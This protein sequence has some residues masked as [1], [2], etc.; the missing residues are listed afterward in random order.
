[1]Q[2]LHQVITYIYEEFCPKQI[3]EP[4]PTKEPFD[5]PEMPP[6]LE[7]RES[8]DEIEIPPPPLVER[9]ERIESFDTESRPKAI[10]WCEYIY[11]CCKK[12]K[13]KQ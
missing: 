5:D 10:T 2:G 12:E 13:Q 1:M 6:L 8:F 3:Q 4:L 7:Y 9:I 11:G